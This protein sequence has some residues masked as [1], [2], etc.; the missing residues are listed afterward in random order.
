LTTA[1]PHAV[2]QGLAGSGW[3]AAVTALLLAAKLE[4]SS[5]PHLFT[6]QARVARSQ[7]QG[8]G[9]G[10]SGRRSAAAHACF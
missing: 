10:S 3:R 9:P 5:V 2:A 8:A 7:S 6:L 1:C 4:E